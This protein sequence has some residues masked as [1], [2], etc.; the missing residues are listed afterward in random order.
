MLDRHVTLCTCVDFVD[1]DRRLTPQLEQEQPSQEPE[2]EQEEQL[3]F[4]L[5]LEHLQ[6]W[7]LRGSGLATCMEG[8]TR[9]PS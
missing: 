5:V 1:V 2:Q 3:L 9:E 6:T 7:K 4:M 8:H